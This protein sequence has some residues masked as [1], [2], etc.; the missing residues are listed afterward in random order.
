M[1]RPRW[2]WDHGQLE[3]ICVFRLA[4]ETA[5]E[6]G[7]QNGS[8]VIHVLEGMSQV[9][10]PATVS[11]WVLLSEA[12]DRKASKATRIVYLG[13]DVDRPSFDAMLRLSALPRRLPR[14]GPEAAVRPRGRQIW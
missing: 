6:V 14:Q 5:M 13:A 8:G 2:V 7:R 9:P 10:M 4:E 12:R 1:S 11:F 3:A